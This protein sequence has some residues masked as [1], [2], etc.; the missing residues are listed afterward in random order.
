MK[1]FTLK[2]VLLVLVAYALVSVYA[3]ASAWWRPQGTLGIVTDY[4]ANIRSVAP[5]GPA[6]RAGI[7]AGDRIDLAAT[8]WDERRYVVGVAA[9]IP[10]GTSV[11]IAL[12]H[13]GA[14]RAIVLTAVPDELTS[15]DRWS[16]ALEC[17]ASL[18][19]I[20]VGATLIIVRPG[21]ATWG[22]GLYCLLE[23]P[24]ALQPFRFSDA[25]TALAVIGCYD[26]VQNIGVV[27]LLLFALDFPR[28]IDRP[29]HMRVR[30]ALPAIFAGLAVM[31]LYPDVLNLVLARS[32]EPEN[33]LLQIVFGAVFLL[34]VYLLYD[35]YRRIEAAERERMRWV[36]IGFGLGL[37]S[38]YVGSTLIFSSLIAIA[39][40]IWFSTLLVSLNVLLPLSVAHA[41]VRH[42]VLDI[43]FV[44][45][46]T[47]IYATLTTI[48]A[49]L[50]A[51]F[52]WLF[53]SVLEEFKLSRLLQAGASIGVAFAFDT[54]HKR[55]ETIIEALFFK[56]R[57]AAQARLARLV[58][59]LPQAR[60]EHVVENVVIDEVVDALSVT[61]GAWFR[62]S[63]DAFSRT[64]SYGWNDIDCPVL[65]DSDVLVLSLRAQLRSIRLSEMPWRR[66]DIPHGVRAPI[67]AIPMQSRGRLTGILMYG[68]HTD[69]N[70]IDP[71]EL[72][73]LE[74][75]AHAASVGIDEIEAEILRAD[76]DLKT[77]AFDQLNARLDE[78]RRSTGV[79]S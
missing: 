5:G 65:D 35:T 7:V 73:Q 58:E 62:L 1:G 27:G 9:A 19:F 41:V 68:G 11:H 75:L 55:T 57:R 17:V 51:L 78:L 13:R 45:S 10:I 77:V 33:H 4:G 53:G 18:I 14:T 39:P 30:R 67:V 22:F 40:P 56:K 25:R 72:R 12:T 47:L 79:P 38:Y 36:L 43:N 49:G 42:R 29:L 6:D 76:F 31:T 69:G 60:S 63:S 70:D 24:T 37:M 23:L 54:L 50:F 46:R 59:E 3:A 64:A 28:R 21:T 15:T 52:D 61:S 71:D 8:R 26:I 32:A 2:L 48:L 44:V 20:V 74:R 66:V 34:A 16:L